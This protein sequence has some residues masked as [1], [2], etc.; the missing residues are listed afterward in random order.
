MDFKTDSIL[1][2][3]LLQVL[4]VYNDIYKEA[5]VSYVNLHT[6]STIDANKNINKSI[7]KSKR[8]VIG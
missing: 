3:N 1:F 2:T 6:S 4:D 5:I 8:K 7:L